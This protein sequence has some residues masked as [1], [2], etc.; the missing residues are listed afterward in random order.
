MAKVW[1]NIFNC[2]NKS[3]FLEFYAARSRASL[4][5]IHADAE[6]RPRKVDET[7]ILD[8]IRADTE[9]GAGSVDDGEPF[10]LP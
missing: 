10:L 9:K 5:V 2:I 4:A 8:V 1:S 6:K 7:T 3:S